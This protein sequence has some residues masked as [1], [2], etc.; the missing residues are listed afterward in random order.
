MK[1]AVRFTAFLQNKIMNSG[2]R[3]ILV[4]FNFD[5]FEHSGR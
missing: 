4:G 2:D 3:P 5:F 1:K